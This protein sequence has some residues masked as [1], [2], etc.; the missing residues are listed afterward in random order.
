MLRIVPRI[1]RRIPRA[2]VLPQF[3]HVLNSKTGFENFGL[4][5]KDGNQGKK[6]KPD[7]EFEFKFNIQNA[8]LIGVPSLWMLYQLSNVDSGPQITWLDFYSNYL[9]KGLVD[10]LQVVNKSQV[11]VFL[12]D[13]RQGPM[14]N[15]TGII[16]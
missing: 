13:G 3:A 5:N 11:R 1:L 14:S 7:P 4:G 10:H 2:T 9:E 16:F 6:Q 15:R 8:V 12:K